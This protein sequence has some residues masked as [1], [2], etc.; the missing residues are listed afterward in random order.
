MSP[1]ASNVQRRHTILHNTNNISRIYGL[2]LGFLEL[3]GF[4]FYS[5]SA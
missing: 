4:V 1:L 2:L 3:I 5:A